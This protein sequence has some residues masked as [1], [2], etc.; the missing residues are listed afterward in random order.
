MPPCREVVE[1]DTTYLSGKE[2]RSGSGTESEYLVTC[3]DPKVYTI[4]L[5]LVLRPGFPYSIVRF[6]K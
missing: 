4:L 1:D 6:D 5:L 2:G 3:T